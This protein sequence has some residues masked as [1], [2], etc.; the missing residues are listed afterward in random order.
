MQHP[1]LLASNPSA[2]NRR[3]ETQQI[4]PQAAQP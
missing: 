2:P 1:S 3:R 4:Q